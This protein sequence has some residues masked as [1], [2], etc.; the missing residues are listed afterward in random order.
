MGHVLLGGFVLTRLAG[1]V[2]FGLSLRT[3][4]AIHAIAALLFGVMSP[5]LLCTY[6]VLSRLD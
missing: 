4:S 5:L 2:V 6:A 1:G 3:K